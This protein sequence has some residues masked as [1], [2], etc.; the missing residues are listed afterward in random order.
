[1]NFGLMF[2]NAG[3]YADGDH[4]VTLARAAEEAGFES[5]WAVEHVVVPAG[6]ESEYPYDKSGRMPGGEDQPIPDPLVWLTWAAAA[7]E[8]LRIG[9]GILILPQRNPVVLA[10]EAATIDH[11]TGGR[12]M[13]GIGVGW[14]EEEFD[15]LGVPFQGRGR[16]ADE[17][18][19]AMRALWTQDEPAFSGEFVDFAGAKMWPKPVQEGG[20]PIVVGGH[21]D[22]AARRAGRL[23][24]G[25][26]PGRSKPETLE[27]LV[28]VMREAAD[29]A[30]RDPETIELTAGG[31]VDPEGVK[32]YADLGVSRMIVPPLSFDPGDI[33]DTLLRFGDDVI[34][35][36][37]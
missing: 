4:A 13:L 9:T 34:A 31:A 32:T 5:V 28:G 10:K 7:T 12:L 17:Y 1:M 33:R 27:H 8:R 18:V 15:A 2:A 36:V 25:F 20:V 14:L 19:G 29:E 21:T 30:G 22:A 11:L 6:Y 3:P 24:D 16:R 23:G 37:G 26:F 35:Q